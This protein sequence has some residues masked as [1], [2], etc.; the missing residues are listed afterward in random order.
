MQKP[1]EMQAWFM[2]QEDPLEEEMAT[3]SIILAWKLPWTE[4]P[5]RLQ[6]MGSQRVRHDWADWTW[7]WVNEVQGMI[8]QTF[9]CFSL[10][11]SELSN[12]VEYSSPGRELYQ[13]RAPDAILAYPCPQIFGGVISIYLAKPGQKIV[14]S[15]LSLLSQT[16]RVTQLYILAEIP[17]HISTWDISILSH[18]NCNK[19]Q[20]GDH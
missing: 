3:H 2:G 10:I 11:I 17:S 1:Q 13:V 8:C 19:N 15:L 4:E 7:T 18:Y 5:V 12:S 14:F 9:Q 20:E 6:F 16:E